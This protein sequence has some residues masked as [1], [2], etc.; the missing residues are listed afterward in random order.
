MA[1]L[2]YIVYWNSYA[3]FNDNRQLRIPLPLT[4]R[5]MMLA[6]DVGVLCPAAGSCGG[7]CS[8]P[9]AAAVRIGSLIEPRNPPCSCTA[10]RSSS[11]RALLR[12]SARAHRRLSLPYSPGGG[13]GSCPTAQVGSDGACRLAKAINPR[14]LPV[15]LSTLILN[16]CHIGPQV[17]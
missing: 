15:S 9:E 10:L 16:H 12:D 1:Y 7:A 13:A 2:E 8:R 5:Q 4:K 17:L 11:T 6:N 14:H 3:V